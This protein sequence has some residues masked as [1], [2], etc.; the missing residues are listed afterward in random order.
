MF[1]TAVKQEMLAKTNV[2]EFIKIVKIAN[3][4]RTLIFLV[5]Q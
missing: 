1:M 5:L 4:N 2:S 3:I